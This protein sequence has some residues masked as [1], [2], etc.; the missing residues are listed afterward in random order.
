MPSANLCVADPPAPH[1]G[2]PSTPYRTFAR[3]SDALRH[4]AI[5]ERERE[6][7][8]RRDAPFA[9][10]R[11]ARIGLRDDACPYDDPEAAAAWLRGYSRGLASIER[12]V[13]EA[14]AAGALAAEC[15]IPECAGRHYPFPE[16]PGAWFST[17]RRREAWLAGWRDADIEAEGG[18]A[19]RAGRAR[20][21]CPYLSCAPE[22]ARWLGAFDREQRRR[23]YERTRWQTIAA[24]YTALDRKPWRVV[25]IPGTGRFGLSC[26]APLPPGRE[27]RA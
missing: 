16:R 3:L 22:R 19:A 25:E 26:L 11:A 8:A 17:R 14:R 12:E 4:Q 7:A 10:A 5:R 9:G 23:E 24:R 20:E 27:R 13:A 1:K 21:S 6:E 15:G 2:A 18:A